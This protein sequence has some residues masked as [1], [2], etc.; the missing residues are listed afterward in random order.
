[1]KI[2]QPIPADDLHVAVASQIAGADLGFTDQTR[3]FGRFDTTD[4]SQFSF[5]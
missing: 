3:F 2:A 4:K 1:M 5:P